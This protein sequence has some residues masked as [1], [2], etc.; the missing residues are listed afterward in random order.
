MIVGNQVF[1]NFWEMDSGDYLEDPEAINFM[2][3]P[4]FG[5]IEEEDDLTDYIEPEDDVGEEVFDSA[6][7]DSENDFETDDEE[8]DDDVKEVT[9]TESVNNSLENSDDWTNEEF[10]YSAFTPEM[11]RTRL[12]VTAV[13][14][15]GD[16]DYSEYSYYCYADID[17]LK[18]FLKQ[19]YP[20][21]S[22]IPGQP[23]DRTGKPYRDLKYT[24]LTI[25]VDQSSNVEDVLKTVQSMGYRGEANKEWLE[26]LEKEYLIIEAVLGGIG[27]VAMLVAAISIANTMTM[28]TYERTKEIGIMKV[29]GCTLGNIR[30]MFLAEAAFI[31]LL[32]GIVGIGLSYGLSL[33]A[34]NVIAPAIMEEYDFAATISVIPPWLVLAAIGF[35]TLIGM[36]AG[37]FPAQRATRLSPLA[38]IR[39]D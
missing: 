8:E 26:Q 25:N 15:G 4:L 14:E 37:F 10:S 5:G 2:T 35:S 32:G 23:T 21:N 20:L 11:K 31:G 38:A 28:S 9:T 34:N 13:T 33:V 6:F 36:L 19:N 29:L 39:T 24:M 27:A 18:T 3:S 30:S 16:E 7:N 17:A 12:K 22:V 1:E